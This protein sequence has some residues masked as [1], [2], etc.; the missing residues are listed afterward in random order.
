[1]RQIRNGVFETNSSSVHSITMCMKDE[2]DRWETDNLFLFTGG[3]YFYPEN[4]RPQKNHFYTKEEAIAFER[5]SK[6]APSENFDWSNDEAVMNMLHDNEWYD[7]DYW[8]D[9]YGNNYET[10]ENSFITPSGEKV[11]AFGYT[12]Y[13]G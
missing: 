3:G 1:M 12:G 9:Y 10:F 5:L 2:Y 6:F 13:D 4:N 8:D 11:I 7:F